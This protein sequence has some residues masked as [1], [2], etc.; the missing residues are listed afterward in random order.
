M[1]PRRITLLVIPLGGLLIAGVIWGLTTTQQPIPQASTTDAAQPFGEMETFVYT[2]TEAGQPRI[3]ATAKQVRYFHE[4]QTAEFTDVEGVMNQDGQIVRM[5]GDGGT[6]DLTS[7]T[8]V[9][10][11][12]VVTQAG[13]NLVLRTSRLDFNAAANRVS[14]DQPV[15]LTGPTFTIKGVGMELDL[16][17][18]TAS[19]SSQ[20]Q[21]EIRPGARP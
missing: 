17:G 5:R 10:A 2:R 16:V 13:E 4:Q 19:V 18:Q 1:K 14:T 9:V 21:A 7:R 11:G 6:V 15:E 12:N 20:V 8:G 3:R